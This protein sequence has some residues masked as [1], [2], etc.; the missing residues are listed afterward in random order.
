MPATR[1]CGPISPTHHP[2]RDAEP[3]GQNRQGKPYL[4]RVLG[5]VAAARADTFLSERYLLVERRGKLKALVAVARSV[6]VIIWHLLAD[7]TARFPASRPST[8]SASGR[9]RPTNSSR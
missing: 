1:C 4:K 3:F 8:T 2:V 7:P 6:S 5:E 9:A